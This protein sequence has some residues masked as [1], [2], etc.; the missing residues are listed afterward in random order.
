[1]EQKTAK[2]VAYQIGEQKGNLAIYQ[3]ACAVL[4]FRI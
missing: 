3:P 2:R 1:M 4:D